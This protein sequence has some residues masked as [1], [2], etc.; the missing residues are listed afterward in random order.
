MIKSVSNIKRFKNYS[1]F[2]LNKDKKY[3]MFSELQIE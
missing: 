2:L 1:G 3:I